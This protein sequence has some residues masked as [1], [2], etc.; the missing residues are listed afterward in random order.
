MVGVVAK[1]LSMESSLEARSIGNIYGS[2]RLL[3]CERL[4][5]VKHLYHLSR[6]L[7]PCNTVIS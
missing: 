5:C 6:Q 2:L 1:P 7:Q 4:L 3:V